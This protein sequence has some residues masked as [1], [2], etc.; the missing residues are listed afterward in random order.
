M[1]GTCGSCLSRGDTEVGPRFPLPPSPS[2]PSSLDCPCRGPPF[3]FPPGPSPTPCGGGQC[4]FRSKSGHGPGLGL[5]RV[6]PDGV[7]AGRGAVGLLG[8]EGGRPKGGGA[9]GGGELASEP[10]GVPS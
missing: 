9:V 1:L 8:S 10:R 2:S 6:H 4:L 5:P 7:L 3:P